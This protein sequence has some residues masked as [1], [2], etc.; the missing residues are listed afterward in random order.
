MENLWNRLK[1]EYKMIIQEYIDSGIY[2]SA[3]QSIRT[4][5]QDNI[6]WGELTIETVRDFFVWT[7][8]CLTDMD[9]EDMF[10]DRFLNEETNK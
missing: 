3:P 8:M 9:W 1:P 4:T 10:G 6:F 7:N 5:L 2:K